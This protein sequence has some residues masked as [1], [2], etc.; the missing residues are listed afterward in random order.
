MGR[1]AQPE[2]RDNAA[3]PHAIACGRALRFLRLTGF[4]RGG[5]RI[6]IRSSTDHATHWYLTFAVSSL[7]VPGRDFMRAG[8][9]AEKETGCIYS[10][11]SRARQPIDRT[12][13]AAIR[14]SCT[15]ITPEDLERLEAGVS[16]WRKRSSQPE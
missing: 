1:H 15:R 10:F 11:P 7:E 5:R 4:G 2:I 6:R 8:I 3:T 16:A 12:D 14:Q 13:I 9:V